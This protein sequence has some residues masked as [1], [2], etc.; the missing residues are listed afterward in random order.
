MNRLPKGRQL[1]HVENFAIDLASSDALSCYNIKVDNNVL[2]SYGALKQLGLNSKC[3]NIIGIAGDY[4]VYQFQRSI[5]RRY[6]NGTILGIPSFCSFSQ[7]STD[8]CYAVHHDYVYVT[9]DQS[10]LLTYDFKNG[11]TTTNPYQSFTNIHL[12]DVAV[13]DER[14]AVLME[15]RKIYFAECGDC[16]FEN[17]DKINSYLE[18]PT[19]VQA[20]KSLGGNT[21]YALGD[22]C[23]KITFSADESNIKTTAIAWGLNSVVNHSVAVMADKIIFA[24]L[25]GLY[26]L[27]G[28]KVTKI[29][30]QM[31]AA[32]PSYA[33]C[34][35]N[36][37]R[38]KY[39]LSVVNGKSR[40][41][42]VLDLDN[43]MCSSIMHG[44]TKNICFYDGEDYVLSG[45][46]FKT[47][48]HDIATDSHF[49][50]RGID[51][52][53]NSRKYLRRLIINTKYDVDVY[54]TVD[55]A[56]RCYR[57]KGS[58]NVQ[59]VPI[60]GNGRVFD[61][62]ICAQQQRLNISHFELL[63]ETYKEENYGN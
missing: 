51:F 53:S 36:V 22:T 17:Y 62:E 57:I 9:Y 2:R 6:K 18:L 33:D 60:V 3:V 23:Y 31:D 41:M 56:K 37:W 40:T 39:A 58:D 5:A 47:I 32:I 45:D 63:A 46:R 29:F 24:T 19:P 16:K 7:D 25:G 55:G 10:G 49:V 34:R 14:P 13:V 43:G 26:V 4:L 52:N 48:T 20:I 44:D 59:S 15:E 30:S 21:L 38:G 50:R 8:G 11:F 42:Y 27:R 12:N 28:D 61:V 35:G 54:L 1:S